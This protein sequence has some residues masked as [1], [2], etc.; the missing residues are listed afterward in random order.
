MKTWLICAGTVIAAALGGYIMG[1]VDG[2]QIMEN[3]ITEFKLQAESDLRQEMVKAAQKEEQLRQELQQIETKG[4]ADFEE[5]EERY[6]ALL[7]ELDAERVQ[8]DQTDPT[9]GDNLPG[10][11]C[12]APAPQRPCRCKPSGA[13]VRLEEALGIARDC[14]ALAIKYNQLLQLYQTAQQNE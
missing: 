14:D 6:H 12:P 11:A 3:A 10:A 4:A 13:Y 5:L 1:R 8:R 9:D 2:N 7:A